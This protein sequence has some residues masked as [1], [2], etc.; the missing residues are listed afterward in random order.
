MTDGALS[1]I[2]GKVVNANSGGTGPEDI[3]ARKY[4][5]FPYMSATYRSTG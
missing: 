5:L 4:L 3:V 1:N 2:A